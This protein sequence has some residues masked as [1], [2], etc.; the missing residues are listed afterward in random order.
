MLKLLTANQ[1]THA[2][3]EDYCEESVFD[4]EKGVHLAPMDFQSAQHETH[5]RV[6]KSRWEKQAKPYQK[7]C[8]QAR[9][10]KKADEYHPMRLTP[11]KSSVIL[12][13]AVAM[14]VYSG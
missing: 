1:C 11:G 9:E 3:D 6:Q 14:I 12:G 5:V 7:G 13:M 2:E 4:R 10:M 8:V